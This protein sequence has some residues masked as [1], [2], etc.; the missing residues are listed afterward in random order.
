MQER[1]VLLLNASEEILKVIDWQRAI[2]LLMTGKAISPIVNMEEYHIQSVDKTYKL[3]KVLMLSQYINIPY[4]E[5]IPSRRNVF[6]RDKW[7]CQYCGKTSRDN[8]KMT[9]D[10]IIPRSRGG[11]SS[12][13]NLVAACSRCNSVKGNNTPKECGMKLYKKPQ[14]PTNFQMH[15]SRI[16]SNMLESWHPWLKKTG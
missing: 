16:S 8:A 1:Q 14:K 3:P 5:N 15:V 2:A 10:H 12:W 7:K 11:D 4:K 13:T 9:I 6:I